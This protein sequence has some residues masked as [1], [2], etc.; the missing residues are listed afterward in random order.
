MTI[1]APRLLAGFGTLTLLAAIGLVTSRPAHSGGGP[2]PVTVVN[3]VQERDSPAR[4]P[5]EKF[6]QISSVNDSSTKNL[7]YTIPAG[8]QLVVESM[9]FFCGN[10]GDTN[11]YVALVRNQDS[12]STLLSFATLAIG[13]STSPFPTVTQPI[14]F[15]AGPGSTISVDV[16]SSGN[17]GI[18]S[19]A[20]SLSGYLVD[21]P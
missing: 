2:V 20:V 17:N 18:S 4:Q 10:V 5:V 6:I 21:V 7:L 3:A 13:P 15:H 12:A 19:I 14:H 11:H 1:N 9:T 16:A 8:K